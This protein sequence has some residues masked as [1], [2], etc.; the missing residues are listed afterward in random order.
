MI[1]VENIRN[2]R[3]PK[4]MN[5]GESVYIF[6]A[7]VVVGSTSYWHVCIILTVFFGDQSAFKKVFLKHNLVFF[8]P[9]NINS[10]G[11]S[12]YL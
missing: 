12:Y 10:H 9:P 4:L 11:L 3:G 6:C 1:L 5:F 8:F 7:L 2:I